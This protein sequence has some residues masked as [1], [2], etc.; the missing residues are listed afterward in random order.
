MLVELMPGMT[1]ARVQELVREARGSFLNIEGAARV[2]R[3]KVAD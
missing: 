2:L 1:L 3:A